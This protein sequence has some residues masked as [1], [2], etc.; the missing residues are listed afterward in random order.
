MKN[1]TLYKQVVIIGMVMSSNWASNLDM[2]AQNG[3]LDFDAAS[4]VTGQAPRYVGAPSLPPSPYVGPPL[5]PAPAL[6]QPQVD[7]FH[8]KKAKIPTKEEQNKDYIKNPTW[9]KL[10]FGA[11]AIGAVS[12]GIVKLKSLNKLTKN[13]FNKISFKSAKKFIVDKGKIVSDFFKNGW[14][15]FTNLFKKKP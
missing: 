12:V 14:N 10:L 5:P 15:K 8:Q 2:L 7:E 4:F 3:V 1:K 13:L 9:K 11:L 6:S